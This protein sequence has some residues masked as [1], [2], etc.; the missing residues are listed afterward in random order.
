MPTVPIEPRPLSVTE[1]SALELILS[2]EFAGAAELRNQ[3]DRTEV[4]ARWGADSASINLRVRQPVRRAAME[5]RLV[6]VGAQVVD[7][8]GEYIG[9]LLVWTD[10]GAT[11]SSLEYAWVTDQMPTALPPVERIRLAD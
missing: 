7:E 10:N 11:L 6:P 8:L 9:E 3:L 4:V 5:T 1:R 2:V